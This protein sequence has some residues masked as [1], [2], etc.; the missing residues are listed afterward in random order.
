MSVRRTWR[1]TTS[2]LSSA[3]NAVFPY[4]VGDFVFQVAILSS[5]WWVYRYVRGAARG[6]EA[7][8]VHNGVDVMNAEKA[9]GLYWEP[10]LQ[11]HTSHVE[12]ILQF[13][14][15]FYTNIHLP[16]I[17]GCLVWLYLA[18]RRV[19]PFFRD[20]FLAL[21]V[22]GIVGYTLVPTAPPRLIP[23]SGIVDTLY[24]MSHHSYQVGPLSQL[25]NPYAAMPS[26]HLAYALFLACAV[27]FLVR[28]RWLRLLF[29]T[30]PFLMFMA[31]TVTG[32]HWVLDSVGG[33]VITGAAYLFV[34]RTVRTPATT[35]E[36]VG[37]SSWMDRA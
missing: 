4:G 30:Y 14:N 26:L 8:A 9:L 28:R 10:W 37:A 18:R 27:A 32:N 29:A 1:R 20:W 5:T 13:F 12:P 19:F 2:A 6:A 31:I 25:A 16:A 15:W 3:I 21:N 23:S 33:A 36:L 7:L 35:V 17:L 24:I 34:A 11:T 22:L